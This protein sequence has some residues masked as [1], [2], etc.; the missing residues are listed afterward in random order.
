MLF[1]FIYLRNWKKNV[2]S[3]WW[4]GIVIGCNKFN[5]HGKVI[6]FYSAGVFIFEYYEVFLLIYFTIMLFFSEKI[7]KM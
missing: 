4:V 6:T 7:A 2:G 3:T 5:T 1:F